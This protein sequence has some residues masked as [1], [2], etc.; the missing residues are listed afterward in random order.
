M[1]KISE[2]A[3]AD[4][5]RM[6]NKYKNLLAGIESKLVNAEKDLLTLEDNFEIASKKIEAAVLYIQASAYIATICYIAIEYI[7]VRSDNQLNDGR[8]YIN[9][10]IMLLEEVFGNHT[11]DSLTL[12]DEIHEYLKD[13]LSDEWKYHFICSF[14]YIIDYFKYCYGEN[15]KW[16]QNFIEIEGRF[17]TLGKNMIDFKS[18]IKE[19]SPELPG[20]KFRV[21]MMELVKKLLAAAAEQY[22]TKYELQDKRLDDM[23][24]ALNIIASLR[25]IHVYLNENEES[26]EKKKMYDLWKKKMDAD[27]KKMK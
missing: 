11:D 24:M 27:I 26:E 21:K 1:A 7:D 14:G 9:K 17:A 12:N 4:C 6:Q 25:R 13:K 18:Y 19:L 15:S 8:R 3:K 22:R 2:A 20:Y 16:L 23:K 5:T 10:A